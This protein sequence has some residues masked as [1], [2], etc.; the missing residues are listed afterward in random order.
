MSLAL[1]LHGA[2][3]LWPDGAGPGPV[4]IAGGRIAPPG[5]GRQVDLSGYLVLPG[6]VDAHGDGFERHLAP[7]RG[8]MRDLGAGLAAAEAELAANGITTAV[9]AQFYSWE[10]GLRGPDFA[11]RV[12]EGWS[13]RRGSG[14]DLRIQLRFE[15][16][17]L[18]DYPAFEALV[19]RHGA[20]YVVFNDHLP[21]D[22]LSQGRRPSRLTGQ[23]LKS[24]RSPE[25][26]LAIMEALHARQ[27][28]VPQALAGLAQRL[29]ARGV[30][31]G[32]HD[33][34]TAADRAFWRGIGVRIAEFPETREAA[35]AAIEAGDRVVMGAPNVMRGGSHNGNVP[36]GA[37]VDEGL[38]TALASDYHFPSLRAAALALA[39]PMGLAAAWR[40]VSEGPAG[41]LGLADRGRI[42]PGLRADLV[43]LE[44]ETG[45]VAATFA[46]GA[47]TFMGG[48]VA[49]RFLD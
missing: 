15:T 8:A 42:A 17:M 20:G 2:E 12:L 19:A 44:R 10:G 11:A 13:A 29:S 36:A 28:E 7:R 23:A 47:L 39:E 14:T 34:R 16:H 40:L 22:R 30:R 46:G 41:L 43:V 1:T 5:P 25:A 27:A 9:L 45:R 48:P 24:G 26:H 3:V 37:L 31:L 18:D 6:I 49:A 21:H 32:S 35:L 38:V 4:G 33:D